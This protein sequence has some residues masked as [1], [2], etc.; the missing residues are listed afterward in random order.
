MKT[1]SVIGIMS[2]TSLDGVDMIHCTINVS[3]TFSFEINCT[4]TYAYSSAWKNKLAEA[5]TWPIEH[6]KTF[7]EDYTILLSEYINRFISENGLTEIDFIASHGHTTLHQPEKGF[8]YQIGNLPKLAQL[9]QQKVI[10]DFRVQDVK[11]GGQ[12]APL[13]PIGD[14]L[15]FGEYDACV[16]LGGFANISFEKDKQRI[17]YDIC[18]VN[19]VLNRYANRLGQ[20]F[21]ECGAIARASVP[22]LKLLAQLEKLQFYSKPPP[23]SLGIEW[24]EA[25]FLP[26]LNHAGLNPPAYLG[27][28]G[29]EEI[30]ATCT[31]HF[32]H[33]IATAISGHE[34]VLFTGG[35]AFNTYLM[36][37][38]AGNSDAELIVP[39]HEVI[40]YKEALIFALLGVLKARGEVNVL[41]SV[42]GASQDH[43]SGQV[44]LP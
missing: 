20:E 34:N 25:E 19:K 11:L 8:T 14:R 43:S 29:S 16:N 41:G 9:T 7:D 6:I 42:T 3:D 15:L 39:S 24:L 38:I 21:D 1:Y 10:C 17:A 35:G 12:G 5:H 13:V 4:S 23:K 33:Q 26:L 31:Q 44:Y 27:R 28:A 40:N 32:A 36:E 30:I 37:L 2:G 18:P 22:N